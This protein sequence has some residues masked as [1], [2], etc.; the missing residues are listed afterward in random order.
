MGA[1]RVVFYED[2]KGCPALE[3]LESLQDKVFV[4][5]AIR[6]ERLKQLGHELR[7]PEVDYLRDQIY[8]L[9][10]RMG[11]VNYRILYFFHG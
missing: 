8:E 7:R 11:H 9:R 4:K 2:E 5:G 1:V 10:W 6:V 3:W